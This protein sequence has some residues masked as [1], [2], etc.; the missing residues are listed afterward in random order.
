MRRIQNRVMGMLLA[1][2]LVGLAGR[3]S[4]E[5]SFTIAVA[6]DLQQEVL[7]AKDTRLTDRFQWLVDNRQALNLKCVLQVGD[8]MNWDTPDHIQYERA[9]A[10]VKIL[11]EAG[12][13]F[14]FTIGNHDTQATGGTPEKPGGSARPGNTHDNQ[15]NTTVYNRYFP[16]ARFKLL[17]GVYEPGKIDN[18]WHT[19]QAGGLDWLVINLELWPRRGAVAWAK[20]DRPTA[21][22]AQR[23]PADPLV[24]EPPARMASRSSSATAATATTARST[25]S[26]N[27]SSRMRT[28]GWC[29]AATPAGTATGSTTATRA[30]PST[31]SCRPTTTRR[32]IPSVYLR[33]TPRRAACNRSQSGGHFVAN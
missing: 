16:L 17:G 33:S 9:S 25:S 27:W 12:L 8:F 11:D 6:P 20:T 10:A 1:C 28:S 24:P 7:D 30:T 4:G 23:D 18:A 15:R 29:F 21:S 22:I 19:F 2:L 14:V 3:A 26:T 13:P 5:D 32:R 31:S